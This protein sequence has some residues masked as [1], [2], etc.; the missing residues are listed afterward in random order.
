MREGEDPHENI[1]NFPQ[2]DMFRKSMLK[3]WKKITLLNDKIGKKK[4]TSKENHIFH[5]ALISRIRIQLL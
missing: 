5:V 4:L 3:L 2:F 1:K